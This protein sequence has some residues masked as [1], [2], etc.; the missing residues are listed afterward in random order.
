MIAIGA[1][2]VPTRTAPQPRSRELS[3]GPNQTPVRKDPAQPAVRASPLLTRRSS[4]VFVSAQFPIPVLP[5]FCFVGCKGAPSQGHFGC[6]SRRH[7]GMHSWSGYP[8]PAEACSVACR[9]ASGAG[10]EPARRHAG[11]A[12]STSRRAQ[13]S[14]D[15]AGAG[16]KMSP[17]PGAPLPSPRGGI[18]PVLRALPRRGLCLRNTHSRALSP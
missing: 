10:W 9:R 6:G 12:R 2:A 4:A 8:R 15:E 16:S 11:L 17:A 13:A 7:V 1:G 18:S 5:R 3:V 14:P